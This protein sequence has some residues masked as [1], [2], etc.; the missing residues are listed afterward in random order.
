MKYLAPNVK[1]SRGLLAV[2]QGRVG[3][4]RVVSVWRRV[5]VLV[6]VGGG[7]VEGTEVMSH[8]L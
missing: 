3:V 5:L 1:P 6:K 2:G 4:E 7:V 8:C